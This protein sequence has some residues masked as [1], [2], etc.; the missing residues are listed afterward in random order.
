MRLGLPAEVPE[1]RHPSLP[2]LARGTVA[3]AAHLALMAWARW[4]P[5]L[6]DSTPLFLL[7]QL[8]RRGGSV[9]VAS[10]AVRVV[11]DPRPLDVVVELAGYLEPL[12]RVPWLGQRSLELA[13][14][15]A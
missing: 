14:G 8:L 1:C 3:R 5:G 4:L 6:A 10:D 12:E 2:G 9:S 15:D 11:L 13:R 7:G